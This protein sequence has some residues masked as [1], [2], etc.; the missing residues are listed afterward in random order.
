MPHPLDGCNEKLNRAHE[1]LAALRQAHDAYLGTKPFVAD[2]VFKPEGSEI[3]F[4]GR[5]LRPPPL[6][7]G[8]IIGDLIHNL[9]SALDHLVWQL[10]L[11]NGETPT[12]DNQF[13]VCTR[14]ELWGKAREQSL[15]GIRDGHAELI[16][17]V[18]PF[19][20]VKPGN[21]PLARLHKLWNEDKHRVVMT[22]LAATRDDTDVPFVTRPIPLSKFTP[23]RDISK[24]LSAD[25]FYGTPLDGH[26]L[27]R[28]RIE[29]SGPRARAEMLSQWR[30]GLSFVDGI[31]AE[32]TIN[33]MATTVESLVNAF[34]PLLPSP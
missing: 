11:D 9:R 20:S 27:A 29:A 13:P 23:I 5:V 18:Q 10:V 25:G 19:Q 12:R 2:Q 3:I 32:V 16:E 24:M 31:P 15:A 21:A 33:A 17:R 1:H 34:G 14:R 6:R 7:I 28:L 4:V 26:A 22:V 30:A 8:V